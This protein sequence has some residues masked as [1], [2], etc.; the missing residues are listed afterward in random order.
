M[1]AGF[2]LVWTAYGWWLPN[3]PRG[4]SS[5]E[6][7]V[8]RIADLG[9][10]HHGRKTVQ[11]S[12]AELRVFFEKSKSALKHELLKFQP[13]DV[14]LI[15]D[16]F[17]ETMNREKYTCYACSIMEDHVHCLIR[18][19]KHHAE[20]MIANLQAASRVKLLEAGR[21]TDDHPVWGGPGW[22][23]FLYTEDDMRRIV[24]YIE[25]NLIKAG[26]PPQRWECVKPYDGWLPGNYGAKR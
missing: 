25:S 17:G 14:S 1:V 10:L 23:V 24:R 12:R 21:R 20:T 2:H 22:K 9:E 8:E 11:P 5:H 6:I 3:D 18:K 16:A 13:E 19:H 15:A 26:L 7:R 4:S